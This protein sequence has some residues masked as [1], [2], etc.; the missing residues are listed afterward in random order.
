MKTVMYLRFL[1]MSF[2]LVDTITSTVLTGD[3]LESLSVLYKDM[4]TNINNQIRKYAHANV[5]SS[6]DI[7]RRH[8]ELLFESEPAFRRFIHDQHLISRSSIIPYYIGESIVELHIKQVESGTM[9]I[10]KNDTPLLST[11]VLYDADIPLFKYME[12]MLTRYITGTP[13]I[14]LATFM[15]W[16]ADPTAK[17]FTDMLAEERDADTHV[18]PGIDINR[19]GVVEE[20]TYDFS[21]AWQGVKRKLES[22]DVHVSYHG[23][24]SVSFSF[25]QYGPAIMNN[26]SLYMESITGSD[27]GVEEM[28]EYFNIGIGTL[29]NE[30]DLKPREQFKKVKRSIKEQ[31]ISKVN[32]IIENNNV[33]V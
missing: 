10:S 6:T 5:N 25:T 30:T 18:A 23:G 33:G 13:D 31:F 11:E 28:L 19:R 32:E 1:N 7:I 3:N 22:A 8:T 2:G 4:A 27:I 9:S 15:A 12:N 21:L 24:D 17:L 29:M 16:S 14:S 26:V 20:D